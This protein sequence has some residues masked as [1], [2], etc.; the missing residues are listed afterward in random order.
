MS[1]YVTPASKARVEDRRV[2]ARVDGV[3]HG[4]G[5]ASRGS[6]RRSSRIARRVHAVRAKRSGSPSR[7]TIACGRAG[8]SRP[9]RSARRTS[10]AGRCRRTPSRRRRSDDED[11]HAPVSTRSH[12]QARLDRGLAA[13][14]SAVFEPSLGRSDMSCRRDPAQDLHRRRVGR[15]VVRRDDG[16]AQPG[17]RRGDRGGAAA[18]RPTTSIAPSPRRRRRWAEWRDKTPKDRME[19]LLQLADVIDEHA[20]ELRGS[21]R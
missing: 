2:E 3:E 12:G 11:P 6:G 18:A 14:R 7:S 5:A 20:E 4:I 10:G 13:V 17:D 9:A 19:L 21:S 8:S 16:G 15:L 1:R